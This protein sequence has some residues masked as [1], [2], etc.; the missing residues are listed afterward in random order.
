VSIQIAVK[1]TVG[2]NSDTG[3]EKYEEFIINK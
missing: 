1:I 2:K 3:R